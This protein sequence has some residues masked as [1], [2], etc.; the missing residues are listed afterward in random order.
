MSRPF[1][2]AILITALLVP[3]GYAQEAAERAPL[4]PAGQLEEGWDQIDDR[5]VFLFTRL[6]TLEASLDAVEVSISKSTS[7]KAAQSGEARRAGN[8]NDMMDRKGGGPMKWDQ[9]Y[10]TTAEKFFYHPVDRNSTYHTV[11]VLEQKAPVADNQAGPGVPA[12]QGLPVHQRPPQF[13]FIY[14]ANENAKASAESEVASLNDKIDSLN[15]RRQQ[16]EGDQCLLWCKIAFRAIQSFDLDQKA[17][18]LY[19]PVI[20]PADRKSERQAASM[21]AAVLFM[22]AALSIITNPEADQER[23]FARIK[24]VI[25]DSRKR[26]ASAW[27]KAAVDATKK[28]TPES[29]FALLAKKLDDTASNLSESYL[30]AME[31]DVQGDRQQKQVMREQLQRSLVRY[32]QILLGMDEMI[33]SLRDQWSI[34]IDPDKPLILTDVA[35]GNVNNDDAEIPLLRGGLDAIDQAVDMADKLGVGAKPLKIDPKLLRKKFAASKVAFDANSCV[36]SLGYDFKKSE[37]LKDFDQSNGVPELLGNG[38]IRVRPGDTLPHMAKFLSGS[39]LFKIK[40]ENN[41]MPFFVS[42]PYRLKLYDGHNVIL[43]GPNN[44]TVAD[45]GTGGR[46]TDIY[47]VS[48]AFGGQRARLVV[49][50]HGRTKECALVGE[51]S[52]PFCWTFDGSTHGATISDLRFQG[53]VDPEWLGDLIK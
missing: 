47:S 1:Y 45:L 21:K 40:F 25:S 22:R 27:L 46:R 3:R 19:E 2:A 16:L 37:Q 4:A 24:P 14:R 41:E 12:R 53:Q 17:L 9:F 52:D 35:S 28:G 31:G 20:I 7:R 44:Q 23:T 26:L 29:Q 15:E 13:D 10:G 48:L 30:V 6:A 42:G 5:L 8:N 32:A 39:A 49:N 36:L 18:L 50:A 43:S 33:M 51:P 11:T 34:E 38:A